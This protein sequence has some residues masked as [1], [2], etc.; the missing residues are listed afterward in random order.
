MTDRAP[1]VGK[2]DLRRAELLDAA[3]AVLTTQGN[4][5]AAMRDF[6]AAAGVRLG[7]LQH[8]Y[9]TRADLLQ[10][11]LERTLDRSLGHLEAVAQRAI[12]GPEGTAVPLQ[13]EDTSRMVAALL[14]AQGETHAV[15]LAVEIWAI[16]AGDARIA[17][18]LRSF[19]ER[20]AHLAGDLVGQ[21][22]PRVEPARRAG[23]AAAL[24][25]LVE[26]SSVVGSDLAGLRSDEATTAL[27][28]AAQFLIHDA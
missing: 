23:I 14:Q 11:V 13:R 3:E 12:G 28:A 21:A 18:V 15:R 24:V 20:Y 5:A 6:A 19:Y 9:P 2:G 16:A 27:V 4:A 25:T 8:Y 7:H 10:A 22:R 1:A 26:G 17:E